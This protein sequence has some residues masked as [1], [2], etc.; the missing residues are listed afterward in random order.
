MFFSFVFKSYYIYEDETIPPIGFTYDT[1]MTASEFAETKEEDRAILMLKT[2]VVQD[3]DE[4]LVSDVL[5]HYDPLVDGE[6]NKDTLE[7]ISA[8]HL[9]ECSKDTERTTSSYASTITAD[10]EKYAF[11]SIPADSG[12]SAEV[13]G[14]EALILD[15]NGF[16]AVR[17]FEGDNRIVFHYE[18]PG[19]KAGILMTILGFACSLIYCI[20]TWK[21]RKQGKQSALVNV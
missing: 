17:V 21:K 10:S 11:Y 20:V 14:E 16:M 2:L 19:L 5:R 15:I 6:A 3:E 9:E 18:V 12:W 7:S 13:N 8:A 1:Y 4:L